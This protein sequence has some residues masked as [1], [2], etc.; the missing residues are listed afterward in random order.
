MHEAN[1]RHFYDVL[2]NG[3]E[4]MFVPQ[5]GVDMI[6]ILQAMYTSAQTGRE[7]LL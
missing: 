1:L 7:V 2:Q 6:K 3:V 4:P 5:Q